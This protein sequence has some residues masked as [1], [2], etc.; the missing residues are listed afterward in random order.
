MLKIGGPPG[1]DDAP[2]EKLDQL[3]GAPATVRRFLVSV[4]WVQG[5]PADVYSRSN[6]WRFSQELMELYPLRYVY[7]EDDV[8]YIGAHKYEIAACDEN[9]VSLRNPEFPLFG[10]ELSRADF[11]EKLK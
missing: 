6:A 7:H 10:K 8:V 1:V 5:K 4:A 9:A 2:P 11:E 3:L